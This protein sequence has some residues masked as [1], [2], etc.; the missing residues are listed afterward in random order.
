VGL[1][2]G[3]RTPAEI[4]VSIAAQLLALRAAETETGKETS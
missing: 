1:P 4:A 3:S 2:I